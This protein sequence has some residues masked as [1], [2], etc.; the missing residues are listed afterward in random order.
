MS[1][2]Q[3]SRSMELQPGGITHFTVEGLQRLSF[4]TGRGGLVWLTRDGDIKDYMLGDGDAIVLCSG[5]R[6][7]LSLER[8]SQPV[9]M[10]I[11]SLAARRPL[12]GRLAELFS[13][14]AAQPCRAAVQS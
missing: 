6:V 1:T 5:D 4:R 13:F 10:L 2:S 14:H 9:S 12:R 8:S 3:A 7:W 11:E